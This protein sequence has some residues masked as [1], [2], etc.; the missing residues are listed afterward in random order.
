MGW[1]E[2]GSGSRREPRFAPGTEPP[3]AAFS[4]G[5]ECRDPGAD[6]RCEADGIFFACREP[7]G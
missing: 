2:A 6:R 7:A 3:Q 5:K 4:A 1:A